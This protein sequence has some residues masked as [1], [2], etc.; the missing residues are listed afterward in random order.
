MPSILDPYVK[1][2]VFDGT[3]RIFQE[4]TNA[5][6]KTLFPVFNERFHFKLSDQQKKSVCLII[7]VKHRPSWTAGRKVVIGQLSFSFRSMG[8]E[9]QHWKSTLSSGKDVEMMHSLRA[10]VEVP[11]KRPSKKTKGQDI[12]DVLSEEE[13]LLEDED[14]ILL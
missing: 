6:H 8:D 7:S 14:D 12:I 1:V 2:E 4:T 9:L 5:K 10:A 11:R 13:N 3:T